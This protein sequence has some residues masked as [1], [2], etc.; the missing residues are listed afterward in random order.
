MVLLWMFFVQVLHCY[1]SLPNLCYALISR[2]YSYVPV[3]LKV[4]ATNARL[5]CNYGKLYA[6]MRRRV[7]G[8]YFNLCNV[9]SLFDCEGVEFRNK[10]LTN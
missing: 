8:F 10:N 4:I 5:S 7:L 9:R 1:R 6:G 3:Y 2:N